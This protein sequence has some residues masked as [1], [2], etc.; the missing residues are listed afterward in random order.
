MGFM[1]FL[2]LVLFGIIILMNRGEKKRRTQLEEKLKK[3]DR[4]VT[5]SGITGKLIEVGERTVRVEIAAGVN[6]TMVKT[7]IE[8]LDTGDD[9][10]KPAGKDAKDAKD[11]KAA[12]DAKDAKDDSSSKD[13]GSKGS[14][15]KVDKKK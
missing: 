1:L 8:G 9:K 14:K 5:R 15:A 11:G 13:S 4:V 6:V 12:K 7:A 3:G 2:P 10:A